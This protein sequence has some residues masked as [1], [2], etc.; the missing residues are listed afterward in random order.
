MSF[1]DVTRRN[2][3]EFRKYF[4]LF[5]LIDFVRLLKIQI[6]FKDVCFLCTK[7]D[8]CFRSHGVCKQRGS[9]EFS[10]CPQVKA[11]VS[12]LMYSCTESTDIVQGVLEDLI[13]RTALKLEIL[14]LCEEA[15]NICILRFAVAHTI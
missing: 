4:K 11:V 3:L 14:H 6:V 15:F 2:Q 8:V 1:P 12:N 7:C 9:D 13:E 10:H 5:L